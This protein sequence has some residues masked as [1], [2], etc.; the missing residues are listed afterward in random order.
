MK[1][2]LSDFIKEAYKQDRVKDVSEAF[3]EYPPEKE[4]HKGKIENI[5]SE[6]EVLYSYD[7]GDI[8]FVKEYKYPNGKIGYNHLFVIIDKDNVAVPIENF[9]MLISSQVDKLKYKSN[10]L[11]SKDKKNNL[12]KDSIVKTDVIYK[13]LQNQILYKIGSVDKEKIEYYKKSFLK[14]N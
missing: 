8:V 11:L 6:I 10:K 5:V 4:W 7:V 2:G 12:K 13:I 3:K 14:N 1:D 9:A